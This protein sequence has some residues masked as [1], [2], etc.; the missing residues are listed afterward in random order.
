MI[1]AIIFMAIG[2]LGFYP[3]QDPSQLDPLMDSAKEIIN[4]GAEFVEEKTAPSIKPW[5]E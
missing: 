1:K 4:Q 3:Y 2:A 5:K